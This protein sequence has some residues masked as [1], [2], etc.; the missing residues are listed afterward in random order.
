[1]TNLNKK[2]SSKYLFISGIVSYL[3]AFLLG[4]VIGDALRTLGFIIVVIGVLILNREL[5]QKKKDKE[6]D[7]KQN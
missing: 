4:G 2:L 6:L 5:K 7:K 1:M 3:L